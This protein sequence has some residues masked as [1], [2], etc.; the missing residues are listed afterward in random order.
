MALD[1]RKVTMKSISL[2]PDGSTELHQVED[3]VDVEHIDA[4]VADAQQRWQVVVVGDE[5][6]HGPAGPD[7]PYTP[8]TL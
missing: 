1:R 6:D 2:A 5:T 4:Y 8:P 7:G 3:Y